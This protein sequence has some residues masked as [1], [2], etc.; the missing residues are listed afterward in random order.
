MRILKPHRFIW[1]A[2]TIT[3]KALFSF[4]NPKTTIK[5]ATAIKIVR[6]SVKVSFPISIQTARIIATAPIFSASKNADIIFD[7]LIFGIKG[8][9]TA[10]NRNEG[11]KIPTVA[12][13][14]PQKPFNCQPIKVAV[15]K[16]G[17][18]VNCPTAIASINCDLV[19]NPVLTNSA[20]KKANKT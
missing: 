4:L 18:G 19:S 1:V 10:T 9:S 7:F 3:T 17:P 13:I 14:A 11:R 15:D 16:T 8:L 2:L 12:A 5:L 6:Q 20:S